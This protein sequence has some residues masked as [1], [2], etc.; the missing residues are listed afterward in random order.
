VVAKDHDTID[1]NEFLLLNNGTEADVLIGK[2][3]AV[4][5]AV[6]LL[7]DLS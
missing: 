7:D 6:W 4:I 3:T 5:S 1:N 2:E